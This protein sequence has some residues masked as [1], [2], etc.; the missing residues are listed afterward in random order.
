MLEYFQMGVDDV[1]VRLFLPN[2]FLLVFWHRIDADRILHGEPP[3]GAPFKL[4]FMR[5]WPEA[6]AS[7]APMLFKV[8]LDLRGI[9][10]HLWDLEIAQCVI[11]S[12]S[13]IIQAALVALSKRDMK[14]F[15][16]VSW[17]IDPDPIPE[18]VVLVIPEKDALYV[19]QGLFLRSEELI[20]STK[21]IL[22]YRVLIDI[23]ETQDWWPQSSSSDDDDSHGNGGGS[24]NDDNDSSSDDFPGHRG[25]GSRG[26]R[27]CRHRF[28]DS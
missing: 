2:D 21:R 24:G 9:P 11:R 13:L 16:V 17:C 20:H 26:P 19:E 15:A 22:Q 8:L 6:R 27:P 7:V 3:V 23:R 4:S 1:E 10:A 28:P 18:Q 14:T 25:G 12:S 5:W